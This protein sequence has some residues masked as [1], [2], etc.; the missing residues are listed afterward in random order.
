MINSQI[1]YLPSSTGE[2]DSSRVL[3]NLGLFALSNALEV[4]S[5]D[6]CNSTLG[7]RP[8]MAEGCYLDDHRCDGH[9]D[10]EDG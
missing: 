6:G 10:C 4:T 7:E 1:R 5:V 8:C 3:S 9:W 2:I